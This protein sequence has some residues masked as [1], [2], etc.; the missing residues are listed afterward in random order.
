MPP[1]RPLGIPT[2]DDLRAMDLDTVEDLAAWVNANRVVLHQH[3]L[4]IVRQAGQVHEAAVYMRRKLTRSLRKG[5]HKELG[6]RGTVSHNH[7]VRQVMRPLFQATRDIAEAGDRVQMSGGRLVRW[8]HNYLLI[9]QEL[10][11]PARGDR[12][13]RAPAGRH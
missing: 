12:A 3:S 2:P 10:V 8:Y 4:E 13:G 5:G 7:A 1:S 11:K 6:V 9:V